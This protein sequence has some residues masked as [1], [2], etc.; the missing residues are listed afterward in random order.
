M[1]L[2][3]LWLLGALGTLDAIRLDRGLR[4]EPAKQC[5]GQLPMSAMVRE[6][7]EEWGRLHPGQEFE[8]KGEMVGGHRVCNRMVAFGTGRSA[9]RL[10]PIFPEYPITPDMWERSQFFGD[11][12]YL[13]HFLSSLGKTNRE[14]IVDTIGGSY[15][16]G[17]GVK[18]D[19]T[20]SEQLAE[21]MKGW[22]NVTVI[23]RAKRGRDTMQWL[24]DEQM[25]E[26]WRYETPDLIILELAVN[27]QP[28]GSEKPKEDLYKF[29]SSMIQRL[30][31][32]PGPPALLFAEAFRGAIQGLQ[33]LRMHCPQDGRPSQWDWLVEQGHNTTYGWCSHW[34]EVASIHQQILKDYSLPYFS[35]RDLVW[36]KYS[37]PPKTLNELW[38]GNSH[39][40]WV[41]HQLFA[42]GIAHMLNRGNRKL[43]Q[44]GLPPPEK[45]TQPTSVE[46]LSDL[47]FCKTRISTLLDPLQG[48]P[49]V[50]VETGPKTILVDA[51]GPVKD[52][53]TREKTRRGG[54][55]T[56]PGE[57]WVLNAN[58]TKG[59]WSFY[60]D[61]RGKY[62]WIIN[63][64]A[65]QIAQHTEEDLRVSFALAVGGSGLITIEYLTSYHGMGSVSM[66]LD[67]DKGREQTI[68][69]FTSDCY[70]VSNSLVLRAPE[71]NHTLHAR[72]LPKKE[73]Y[74]TTSPFDIF[75]GNKFKVITIATC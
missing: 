60:E 34:W 31:S 61:V 44:E 16:F 6:D 73:V 39:P 3:A 35:Y 20:W 43:C 50:G 24:H 9:K 37:S 32:L 49:V 51:N 17:E 46:A 18:A 64:T 38:K 42:D 63:P 55:V 52:L 29:F 54:Y 62:G 47:G 45:F 40:D 1:P 59:L 57:K 36:P 28:Y 15:T 56:K 33:E 11:W 25:W 58:V 5:P 22:G 13:R 10:Q 27:D 67:D 69:G 23:N 72:L 14:F 48:F 74:K 7:E 75:E 21:H 12:T 8:D 70:S 26:H 19:E 53:A 2:G 71:G 68:Q 65:E 30:L 4:A 41:A 66:W